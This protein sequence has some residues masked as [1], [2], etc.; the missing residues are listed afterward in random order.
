MPSFD[1]DALRRFPD[2]EAP[3]LV[4]VDATDRLLL[5][6][7]ATALA[8]AGPGEVVVIGDHYGAIALG[9]VALHGARA[10]RVHQ[11]ALSG[12]LALARN[13]QS[14][15]LEGEVRSLPL[16]EELTRGARVVLAQLPR[17]LDALDEIAGLVA[18]TAEP[19]V[20]FFAGGRIK[21][22]TRG[23]ND[24]LARHFEDVSATLGRQKSRALVA[25]SPRTDA[26][27][28][29]WPVR[30]HDDQLDLEIR[31]FGA[32]FAGARVDVGT[33]F[34]LDSLARMAPDARV[35]LDLGS[36][37]GVIATVLVRSRPGLRVIASDQSASAV[38]S[39]R[40]TAEANGVAERIDV[41]RDDAASA[42]ADGSV[43]LV[44]LNPPFHIGNAVH[45]GIA[46]KLFRAAGRVLAPG[47]ELWTVWNSGLR[48]RDTLERHVGPTE[49]I[50][51]NATFTVTVSRRR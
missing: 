7:A 13:A 36:G 15:G 2:V 33:R 4:A 41:V 21:H 22:M 23:M 24:V 34:L 45:P 5:D 12:E 1:F 16:D 10:V 50:A 42:L 51:R 6:E 14:A 3:D 25:R 49:Q 44:V 27:A 46:E 8:A 29:S 39:T 26:V 19:N 37:T 17:S 30:A 9:A 18:R 43:D 48:Y 20:V 28:R 40:A 11:D 38:D 47:G 32:A 31:S 35:A